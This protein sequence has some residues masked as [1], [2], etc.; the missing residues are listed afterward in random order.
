MFSS[1][2]VTIKS[3]NYVLPK[4]PIACFLLGTVHYI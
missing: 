1:L 4:D 2:T 3:I